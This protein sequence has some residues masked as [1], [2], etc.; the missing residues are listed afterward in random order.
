M[1]VVIFSVFVLTK[2]VINVAPKN[3]FQLEFVK[4]I[5]KRALPL[6]TLKLFDNLETYNGTFCAT[7]SFARVMLFMIHIG[8]HITL[9]IQFYKK[10]T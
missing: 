3:L 6:G 2:V 4:L 8:I 10:I 9:L 5:I 7:H 1:R